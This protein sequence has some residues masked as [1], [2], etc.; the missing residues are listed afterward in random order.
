MKEHLS[1]KPPTN[2]SLGFRYQCQICG[3]KL[4]TLR[5]PETNWQEWWFTAD[6]KRHFK[7]RCN[8]TKTK[9]G[10]ENETKN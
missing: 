2:I 8:L 9:I 4:W 1:L 6:E 10:I 7:T 5:G 3:E